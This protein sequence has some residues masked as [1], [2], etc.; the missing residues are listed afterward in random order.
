MPAVQRERSQRRLEHWATDS[1]EDRID[2]SSPGE[3]ED[4]LTKIFGLRVDDRLNTRNRIGSGVRANNVRLLP[5]CNLC[6]CLS[7]CA[8]RSENKDGLLWLNLS[9]TYNRCPGC[10]VRNTDRRGLRH[11][12]WL[13]FV[14]EGFRRDYDIFRM[15]SVTDD[16]EVRSTAPDLFA[17]VLAPLYNNA[18][19]VP[20]RG[21]RKGCVLEASRDVPD[22]AGIDRCSLYVNKRFT[23]ARLRNCDFFDSQHRRRSKLGESQRFHYSG[24]HGSHSPQHVPTSLDVSWHVL[25]VAA[26]RVDFLSP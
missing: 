15:R 13:R 14:R 7:Y 4:A 10:N 24:I 1:V 12:Q 21:S 20:A 8:C 9:C 18:R 25:G 22:V 11:T 17:F 2:S 3:L 16:A 26:E 6:G 5:I 19:K 23:I